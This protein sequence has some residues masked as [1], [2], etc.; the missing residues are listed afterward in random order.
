MRSELVELRSQFA[1]Y[2]DSINRKLARRKNEVK[3]TFDRFAAGFLLEECNLVWAPTK[4]RLGETGEL[5]SFPAF[6]LEM[7][8]ASF[9][10]PVRRHGPG[11]VSESQREF[12]DLAFRMTLMAV[13]AEDTGGSLVIDAPESSLDAVFVS[14]AA[15]VLAAFADP[16]SHNRLVITSNLIEG[17]LIPALV[18]ST[19]IRSAADPRVVTY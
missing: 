9:P 15:E 14:R 7:G 6:E 18:R 16:N 10:S 11:Q 8:G 17:D 2:I 19:K 1:G 13:A 4:A 12:I 5:M 3:E